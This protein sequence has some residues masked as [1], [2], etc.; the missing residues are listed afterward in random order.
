MGTP[1][2]SV[3]VLKALLS[4]KHN[5]VAVYT[6]PDVSRGRGRKMM[7]SEVYEFAEEHGLQVL[8]PASLTEPD[9]RKGLAAL[10]PDV[11]VVAAYGK[12]I[13]PSLLSV[14]RAGFINVH[15]SKLPQ[16]RGPSPVATAIL[17]GQKE[18][19]VS[20]IRMDTGVDSGPIL[21]QRNVRIKPN[22]TADCLS[23]RLFSLGG[24]IL[25]TILPGIC[26]GLIVGEAQKINGVTHT[27]KLTKKEGEVEWSLPA[28]KLDR[29]RRAFTPWPGFHTY[30]K[31]QLLKIHHTE[32][33]NYSHSGR[34]GLVIP[35]ANN[36]AAV[37]V[38]TAKGILAITSLQLEGKSR[39]TAEQF[40]AG[41]PSFLGSQLPS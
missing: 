2:L 9:V 5:I 24:R 33:I 12:I 30:W 16:Y 4:G 31:G 14:P 8:Q 10:D 20:I 41:Y 22:E 37:G 32:A 25:N 40:L 27:K 6:R 18:T 26:N 11:V 34:S 17:D 29:R 7:S 28:E 1:A 38:T 35:I 23:L 39:L 13:P 3:V 21:I 36:K 19:G 15:P